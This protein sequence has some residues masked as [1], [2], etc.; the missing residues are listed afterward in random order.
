[1][2]RSVQNTG[3]H[4]VGRTYNVLVLNLVVYKVTMES[5]SVNALMTDIGQF[6]IINSISTSQRTSSMYIFFKK[7]VRAV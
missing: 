5:Q 2:L 3:I 4:S 7:S 6:N 1:M